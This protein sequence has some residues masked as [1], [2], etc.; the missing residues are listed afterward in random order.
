MAWIEEL[1]VGILWMSALVR[2]V[3]VVVRSVNCS[4]CGIYSAL[5]KAREIYTARGSLH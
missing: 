3:I 4:K 5:G 1:S 2:R